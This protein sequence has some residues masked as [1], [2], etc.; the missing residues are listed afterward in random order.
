MQEI[1][2]FILVGMLGGLARA[3]YGLL[4]SLSKGMPINIK[5]FLTTLIISS[6][7]GGLLGYVVDIDLH[8][9]ALAGYVGTDFLETI[10]TSRIKGNIKLKK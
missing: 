6:V 2:I 8:A 4:K 10:V 9:A 1:I 3:C 5:Y 7:I